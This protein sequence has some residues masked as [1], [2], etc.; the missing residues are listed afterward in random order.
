MD[1]ASTASNDAGFVPLDDK[2]PPADPPVNPSPN[3]LNNTDSPGD[4]AAFE[5]GPVDAGEKE[6]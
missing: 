2:D 5:R 1:I 6:R 3:E 4:D